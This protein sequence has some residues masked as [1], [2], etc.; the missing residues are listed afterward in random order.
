MKD[1]VEAGRAFPFPV[2]HADVQGVVAEG[3]QPWQ[4]SVRL[5]ALESE[6]LFLNVASVPFWRILVRPVVNLKQQEQKSGMYKEA[7]KIKALWAFPQKMP[8]MHFGK[9]LAKLKNTDSE[10]R[11]SEGHRYWG[12]SN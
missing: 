2:D 5:A 4:H 6:D 9:L 7:N 10:A 3:L 11:E 8:L 12:Q 1:S